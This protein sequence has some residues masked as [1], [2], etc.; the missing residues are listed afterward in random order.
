M[1][2]AFAL[3]IVLQRRL[4]AMSMTSI[5]AFGAL[6]AAGFGFSLSPHPA[7]S[8]YDLSVLATFGLT[9]VCVAFLLFMEGAQSISQP[10]RRV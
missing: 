6:I 5:N 2:F 1:T 8:G 3:M 4:P 9:T 7:L 10:P